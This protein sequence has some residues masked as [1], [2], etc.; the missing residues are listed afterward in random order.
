M[1][2]LAAVA[3]IFGLLLVGGAVA[4][5]GDWPRLAAGAAIALWALHKGVSRTRRGPWYWK[6]VKR[7]LFTNRETLQLF[8]RSVPGIA[9]FA[10]ADLQVA[11][12]LVAVYLG[13]RVLTLNFVT[14][15]Y[16]RM[17]R[18]SILAGGMPEVAAYREAWRPFD[19]TSGAWMRPLRRLRSLVRDVE[20]LAWALV[21]VGI[22]SEVLAS[23]LAVVPALLALVLAAATL[24]SLWVARSRRVFQRAERQLL[25][26]LAAHD[27][28]GVVYFSAPNRASVYQVAQWLPLLESSGRRFVVV[29]RERNLVGALAA[30]CESP[31]VYVQKLTDLERVAGPSARAVFYVNSGM[32]NMHMLRLAKFTHVQLLHGESDKGA[33]ANKSAASYD[34]LFVAGQLAIDRYRDAGIE[35]AD[36][37]F[38]VVGRPMI[39]GLVGRR[40]EYVDRP[41]V[42]YAPTWEGFDAAAS[43]CS[44]LPLGEA[45]VERLLALDPPVRVWFKPHPLTG[46]SQPEYGAARARI[47]QLVEA[48]AVRDPGAGHCVVTS[49]VP[50]ND[51]FDES[52]LLI[53]D[54]S[55]VIV[56]YLATGK[57]M[58]VCDVEGLGE[59]GMHERYPTSGGASIIGD[60]D[61]LGPIVDAA[62][63]GADPMQVRRIITKARVLGPF[64]GDAT[65]HLHRVLDALLDGTEL[66][67]L[68]ATPTPETIAAAPFFRCP[69]CQST[70]VRISNLVGTSAERPISECRSCGFV[71]LAWNGRA[72]TNRAVNDRLGSADHPGRDVAMATF[73][74]EVLGGAPAVRVLMW[75]PGISEDAARIAALD[76]VVAVD[77]VTEDAPVTNDPAGAVPLL[78]GNEVMQGFDDP[79]AAFAAIAAAIGDDGLA[80]LSTDLRDESD[81]ATLSF[82]FAAPNRWYWSADALVRCADRHGLLYDAR[83]PQIAVSKRWQRKRY[84]LLSKSP[85]VM[86]QARV[87]FGDHFTAASETARPR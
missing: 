16:N 26:Q 66:P 24:G 38:V 35:L 60:A 56:D 84:I 70:R 22:E 40:D 33:S 78:I 71:G 68:P 3:G 72:R 67:A 20:P 80:V 6:L 43:S 63:F 14:T 51:A 8:L 74:L 57:P 52:D 53:S 86:A 21:F 87:Y 10:L 79:P 64:E 45:V 85:D 47:E 5:L 75:E 55:S 27:P 9:A 2:R 12:A 44:V 48:A 46:S 17:F 11:A 69:I 83:R 37:R 4:I 50:I 15:V 73:G 77:Q 19:T 41:C 7:E 76:R 28:E 42:L 13:A 1:K 30:R 58:V 59:S 81:M 36:D 18:S 49:D 32:K 39:D 25:D 29:T 54:V 31:V 62:L 65:E 23:W 34:K 82:P 61:Q